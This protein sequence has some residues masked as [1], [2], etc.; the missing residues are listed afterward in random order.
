MKRMR[1]TLVCN[2]PLMREVLHYLLTSAGIEVVGQWSD[3]LTLLCSIERLRPDVVFL[4]TSDSFKEPGTCSHLL[5]EYPQLKNV[6]VST[7]HYTISDVGL[8]AR[9]FSDLSIDS[10]RASVLESFT[11]TPWGNSCPRFKAAEEGIALLEDGPVTG[12]DQFSK[13]RCSW[14]ILC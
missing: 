9:Q 4:W 13:R 3:P 8:R 10:I 14:G 11:P 12:W 5:E 2:R 7:N 1:A 6:V